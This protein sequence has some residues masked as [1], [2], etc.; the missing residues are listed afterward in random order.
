MP[1][2]VCDGGVK[3]SDTTPVPATAI[4]EQ[5]DCPRCNA[6]FDRDWSAQMHWD[7]QNSERG[8]M[9]DRVNSAL[10]NSALK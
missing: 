9:D 3:R 2:L 1:K 6:E 7:C 8:W 10:P 5:I 4:F